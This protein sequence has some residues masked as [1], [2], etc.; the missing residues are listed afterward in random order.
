MGQWQILAVTIGPFLI[1]PGTTVPASSENSRGS[2]YITRHRI[3][4]FF[5]REPITVRI[6]EVLFNP[7]PPTVWHNRQC[8]HSTLHSVHLR[9]YANPIRQIEVYKKHFSSKT[10]TAP[11]TASATGM[12]G[13]EH[14]L[15]PLS[16]KHLRYEYSCASPRKRTGLTGKTWH[17]S[18]SPRVFP[19][20]PEMAP[21]F[22]SIAPLPDYIERS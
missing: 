5:I 4:V 20:H 11:H 17:P 9:I 12:L 18:Y 14:P 21:F 22:K 3:A 8:S 13:T 6:K 16:A 10:E 15:V 19:S 7:P 2:L 1:D